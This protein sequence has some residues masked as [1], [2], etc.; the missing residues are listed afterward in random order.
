MKN[1]NNNMNQYLNNELGDLPPKNNNNFDQLQKNN[2]IYLSWIIG[3]KL[4]F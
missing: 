1:N 2:Q 4:L 3:L